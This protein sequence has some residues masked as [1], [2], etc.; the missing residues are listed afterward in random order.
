MNMLEQ[1]PFARLDII[2]QLGRRESEL[3]L[4]L[5]NMQLEQA[6]DDTVVLLGLLIDLD[7]ELVCING[8]YQMNVTGDILDLVGLQMANEVPLNILG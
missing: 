7:Q 2:Q 1:S 4:F 5:G 8:M 3:G 6:V